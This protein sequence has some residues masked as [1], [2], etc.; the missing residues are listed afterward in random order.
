MFETP[1]GAMPN[2]QDG[3][4]GPHRR[5]RSRDDLDG[6]AGIDDVG[7]CRAPGPEYYGGAADA[8]GL[9]IDIAV[10]RGGN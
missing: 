6:D 3:I 4:T 2:E 5:A 1:A 8:L 7:H 10:G 9:E